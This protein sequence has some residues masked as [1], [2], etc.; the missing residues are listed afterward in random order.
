M[1]KKWLLLNMNIYL[2]NIIVYKLLVLVVLTTFSLSLFPGPFWPEVVVS[3]KVPSINEIEVWKLSVLER[4]AWFH[5][6]VN[7]LY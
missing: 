5:I 7:Y 1:K 3:I 6:T 2:S 4:N